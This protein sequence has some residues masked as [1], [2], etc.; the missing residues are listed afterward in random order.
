MELQAGLYPERAAALPEAERH[1]ASG[2]VTKSDLYRAAWASSLGSALE[3][4]DFALYN[5]AAALI[6]G[7]LFF[8]SSDPSLGL[9]AS[10]GTYFL[11]F[12]VRPVG[13]IAFGIL[14]DRLGRKTALMAT[15]LLMGTASTLIGLL[16][17]YATAGIWAPILLVSLRLLQGLGAGAEQAGASVLMAE[18]APRQRRGFFAALPFMGIQLGT[19]A[20]ALV[21]FLLLVNIEDVGQSWVWRVPFLLSVIIIAV[22]IWIRLTLKESPE[23]SKLEARKQVDEKPLANLLAHSKRNTLVVIGLRMGENGASSI[24][25]SLAISYMVAVT[26][27]PGS[28]GTFALLLAGLV[29]A[30]T[31]TL[32]GLWSDR[33]GR[34]PVYRFFACYQLVMAFP[35][36]WVL[37]QGNQTLSVIAIP[38]ALISVWGMFGTQ[39]A[40]L[41]ELFGARHRYIGV[42]FGREISA[43]IGGGIAPL[44]GAM[45]I[46]WAA[47]TY[48]SSALAW[49]PL[50][51][52][53]ALLSIITIV[54]TFVMPETRA[55]N[56]DDL[57]D[58]T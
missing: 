2:E 44:L 14:G 43:V 24:Y 58:A 12:A 17:T 15:V 20:A 29:G 23:F 18:Y 13:G 26:K 57:R 6:F 10:F 30:V 40:L 50:A 1:R 33:I 28:A 22:A 34:R 8:P 11:G 9:I 49:I 36:W 53:V 32:S 5:L 4:Y 27:L 51:A 56:L 41:P 42:A 48:G 37:S 52:Y 16:P 46:A 19:V 39:A 54:T 3:Y 21:Y 47:S 38:V 55:R 25:Q 31:V 7:P 45:I 35:L